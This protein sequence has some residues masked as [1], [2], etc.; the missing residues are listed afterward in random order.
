VTHKLAR[1]QPTVHGAFFEPRRAPGVRRRLRRGWTTVSPV[2]LMRTCRA[3]ATPAPERRRVLQGQPRHSLSRATPSLRLTPHS[4]RDRKPRRRASATGRME[5]A[6]WAAQ[7]SCAQST[8]PDVAIPTPM[9]RIL[10]AVWLRRSVESRQ[11]TGH[12]T[13]LPH[14]GQWKRT[15]HRCRRRAATVRVTPPSAV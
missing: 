9:K 13:S 14:P 11:M 12:A 3:R 6:L 8:R 10:A 2:V 7:W 15:L 5:A 1:I 4:P